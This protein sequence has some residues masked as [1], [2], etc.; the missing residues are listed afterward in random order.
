MLYYPG[1]KFVQSYNINSETR[2]RMETTH[3]QLQGLYVSDLRWH[4]FQYAER[5]YGLNDRGELAYN[6]IVAA[7]INVRG[8][9]TNE[10]ALT[11][12]A[13]RE[14]QTGERPTEDEVVS[15]YQ[16]LFKKWKT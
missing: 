9:L 14:K 8:Y 13:M 3:S 4:I 2:R 7:E 5:R 12:R 15:I 11:K 16:N 6:D 1:E 10:Q